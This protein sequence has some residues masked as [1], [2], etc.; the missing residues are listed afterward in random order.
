MINPTDFRKGSKIVIAGELYEVQDFQRVAKGRGRG[1]VRTKLKNL[2]T[3][4]TKEESL[5]STM[6]I[7]EAQL[8]IK[9]MQYLYMQ[10]EMFYFMDTSTFQQVRIRGDSLEE[11][12]WYLIEGESY[13]ILFWEDKPISVALPASVVLE[14]T[15]TVPGVKGDSVT[16]I[17]KDATVQT[18]LKIKVP[19]FINKGDKVK[20]DTRT[21]E[22]IGRA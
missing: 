3:G 13:E 17:M 15:D 4:T 2:V 14:I 5:D 11:S 20:V 16:N 19:L 18:G 1:F 6:S 8:D 9:E 10:D 21:G 12:K 7:E 22:Y